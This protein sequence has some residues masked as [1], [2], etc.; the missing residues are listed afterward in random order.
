MPSLNNNVG[1][2]CTLQLSAAAVIVANWQ[3]NFNPNN[4]NPNP[5]NQILIYLNNPSPF[6]GPID[7]ST[8]DPNRISNPNLAFNYRAA[9]GWL[10]GYTAL[11]G[12]AQPACQDPG[13][14]SIYF[15]NRGSV[16]PATTGNV[17]TLSC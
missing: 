6:I 15:Y 14:Y 4:Q 1:Y 12:T 17:S 16:L 3:D 7:P 5:N 11:A 8:L 10:A 2:W 13:T 9:N